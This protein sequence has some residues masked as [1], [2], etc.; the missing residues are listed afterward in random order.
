MYNEESMEKE[1]YPTL[2]IPKMKKLKRKGVPLRA[3]MFW[4]ISIN[5]ILLYNL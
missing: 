1:E 2:P 5:F 4:L 3:P